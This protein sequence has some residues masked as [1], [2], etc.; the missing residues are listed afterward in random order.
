MGFSA[1]HQQRIALSH[2]A[3]TTLENDSLLFRCV[4]RRSG[5]PSMHKFI[6]RIFC[7]YYDRAD[8]SIEMRLAEKRD[9]YQDLKPKKW[10]KEADNFINCILEKEKEEL[11]RKMENLLSASCITTSNVISLNN[12]TLK[13]LEKS[14]DD[15]HYKNAPS[16]YIRAILEEYALLDG[17]MREKLYFRENIEKLE[18]FALNRAVVEITLAGNSRCHRVIPVLIKSDIYKTHLYLAGISNGTGTE[19]K[20]V[21]YRIDHIDSIQCIRPESRLSL[22]ASSLEKAI[23]QWG[24]QY[25]SS[26]KSCIRILLSQ[27]GIRK[28]QRYTYQRPSYSSREG[29]AKDIY[30]FNITEYQA[31]VYFFKFGADAV[32]LEPE[33]L[34]QK[35]CRLYKSALL[36]YASSDS[37]SPYT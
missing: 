29:D 19:E 3:L 5:K 20:P 21:S 31:L 33:S 1:N 35:F 12:E 13:I 11:T 2:F 37:E 24:I 36:K 25:L 4:D 14:S 27:E 9:A 26:A 18:N 22:T 34:R 17:L 32:V 23:D 8:A 15:K 28:Y 16:R 7:N 6:N 10:P 30:V